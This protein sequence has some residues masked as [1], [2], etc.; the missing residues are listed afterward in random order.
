M[1]HYYRYLSTDA[2][3]MVSK[4]APIIGEH[5]GIIVVTLTVTIATP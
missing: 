4:N 3:I 2:T 5:V 1:G